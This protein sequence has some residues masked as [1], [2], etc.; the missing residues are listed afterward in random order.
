MPLTQDTFQKKSGKAFKSYFLSSLGVVGTYRSWN[1]L[2]N[3]GFP[4]PTGETF[5]PQHG[6][7]G[8]AAPWVSSQQV[9]SGG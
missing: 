6:S 7:L 1:I 2:E 5:I 4:V 3:L 9:P 8:R